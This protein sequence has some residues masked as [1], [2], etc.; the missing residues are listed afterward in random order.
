MNSHNFT[1]QITTDLYRKVP[2]YE[3]I[4]ENGDVF[5]EGIPGSSY[6]ISIEQRFPQKV[7]VI[8]SVD[9]LSVLTGKPASRNDQGFI[10]LTNLNI[11]GWQ[12]DNENAAEF[13][14]T[15][16]S[17]SYAE[18]VGEPD[19]VGVIAAAVYSQKPSPVFDT[20][21][22]FSRSKGGGDMMG[23]G[24]GFGSSV[25]SSIREVPFER[26]ELIT[27][28]SVFYTDRANLERMGLI[29]KH[30]SQPQP[31]PADNY[32]SPPSGWKG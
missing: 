22:D 2:S 13:Y 1:L 8:V 17:E 29:A 21:V 10:M 27:E 5:I 18:K 20:E 23:F 7:L 24:T 3:Y 28:L 26:G 12:V 19:N 25:S 9:G 32:C 15:D 14:F 31:F 16:R 30:S 6:A 4:A 11:L